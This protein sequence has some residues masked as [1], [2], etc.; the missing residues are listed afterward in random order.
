M[1]FGMTGRTRRASS[2]QF[3]LTAITFSYFRAASLD[4]LQSYPKLFKG[5]DSP[6]GPTVAAPVEERI[7]EPLN[8]RPC[9]L[10]CRKKLPRNSRTLEY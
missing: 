2:Q 5:V 10:T 1:G 7:L 3:I 9:R 6:D 8:F 4:S